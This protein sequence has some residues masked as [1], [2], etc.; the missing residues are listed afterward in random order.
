MNN[1]NY[2]IIYTP[3]LYSL[4][5]QEKQKQIQSNKSDHV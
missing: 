3:N 4:P 1:D 5:F 2:Q